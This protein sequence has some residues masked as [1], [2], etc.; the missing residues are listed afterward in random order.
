M[1]ATR[2]PSIRT[3]AW[4][5]SVAVT[6]VPPSITVRAIASSLWCYQVAVGVGSPVPVE[7]PLLTH[8]FD[9]VQVEVPDHQLLLGVGGGSV[10]DLA[11]GVD[12]IR[13]PVEVVVPV[14]LLTHPVDGADE[15]LVGHGRG[16]LLQV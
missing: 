10:D 14:R 3:S 4:V 7:G 8:L 11:P 5:C 15:V 2:S 1:A 16:R 9:Q 13:R 6:T 12:E